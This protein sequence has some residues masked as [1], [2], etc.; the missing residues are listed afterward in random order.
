MSLKRQNTDYQ[1]DTSQ[2]SVAMPP[3]RNAKKSRRNSRSNAVA[4]RAAVLRNP[5]RFNYR[6]IA[7]A[8]DRS[9][10]TVPMSQVMY[11]GYNPQN[12]L[13]SGSND[14]CWC[15]TE[16]GFYYSQS[17]GA[18]TSAAA[19]TFDNYASLAAIFQMYRIIEMEVE[20][21]YSANQLPLTNTT[22]TSFLPVCQMV[23]DRE[24]ARAVA[25]SNAA[26]QYA[27]CKTFQVGDNL[28]SHKMTMKRPSC[29]GAVEN[30]DG[31]GLA[32]TPV[33]AA[34]QYSP[35]L[36]LGSS[37]STATAEIVPHGY[38]KMVVDSAGVGP[39]LTTGSFM[40]ILRSVMQFRGID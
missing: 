9:I 17:S 32:G 23:L 31:A 19:A 4:R 33:G 34:L 24:D 36:A 6:T 26:Q 8:V 3:R 14:I 39:N 10:V 5:T 16:S 30:N 37:S 1:F 13:G 18:W 28:R 11:I 38:I 27:S 29:Y 12:G 22:G 40:F 25:N 2:T 7:N 21:L 15:V 20:V 35:W